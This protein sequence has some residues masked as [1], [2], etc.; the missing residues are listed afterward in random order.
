MAKVFRPSTREANIL[1]KIESQKERTRRLSINAIKDCIDPLSNAIAMKLVD[2]HLVE[3]TNKNALEDQIKN[4]LVK[5]GR[6]DD[7]EIDYQVAPIR[8]LVPQPHV[9]SLFL[10]AFIIEKLIN[11]K[12]VVDIY[13]SD[14]DIYLN[15][16]QQI[17]KFLPA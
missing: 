8:N 11:H 4:A 2:D 12:D 17:K 13:G 7:F 10:T 16:H 14:E 15:I 1:S 6:S 5:L 3:T 9:V